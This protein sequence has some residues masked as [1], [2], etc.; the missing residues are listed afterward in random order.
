MLLN[1]K[2]LENK[3]QNKVI[4]ILHGLYGEAYSCLQL[5]KILNKH[6]EIHL[7]DMRNHG[8]S[9]FSEKHSYPHMANDI[10]NYVKHHKLEN[11]YIVGHSMGGKAA[12]Y[13]TDNNPD[14]VNK[15]VVLDVSPGSYMSLNYHSPQVIEHL[16]F[17]SYLKTLKP[18]EYSSL[19]E[20]RKT[21]LINDEKKFNLI[22]K[23]LKKKNGKLEWKLNL[24]AIHNNLN[25]ILDGLNPDNYINKKIEKE[26]VFI[27]GE[28]S[29]YIS[30]NDEKLISFI[31][32]NSNIKTIPNAG[33]WLHVE[34]TEILADEIL[35]FLKF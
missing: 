22:L 16:N 27:K 24:N 8:S 6:A 32:P 4:I 5:G 31:F 23:N 21:I 10:A 18:Q 17:I 19:R 2:I 1:S 35:G 12:I 34:Q 25:E 29:D 9:F 30:K 15:L 28:H 13:F 14:I 11:V 3:N 26:T 7:P 33:H 20:F